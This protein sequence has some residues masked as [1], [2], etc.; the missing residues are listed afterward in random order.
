MDF[1]VL[2]RGERIA[3]VSAVLLILIMFIFDWFGPKGAT[4]FGGFDAWQSY[5]L[6]DIILFITALL[7]IALAV[8][9]ASGDE[10]GLPVALSSIVT[11]LGI[12]SVI[13][14][15]ISIISP[16]SQD[17]PDV[18]GGGSVDTSVKVGVF[19]G[20]I[21]AMGVTAGGWLAMQEEDTS[22]AREADRFR[23]RG[24]GG[25]GAS[26]PPSAGP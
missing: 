15:I 12:I 26:P 23:G 5:G 3:G 16:P 18:L 9:A 14:V 22:F 25:P 13:L 11:A 21:A 10:L 6:T 17:V 24:T 8:I 19:L 7:A 1:T 20:L 4:E 2:N